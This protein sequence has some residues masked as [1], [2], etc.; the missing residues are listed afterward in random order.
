MAKKYRVVADG[1]FLGHYYGTCPEVAVEKAV[2]ATFDYH[3]EILG[4]PDC[5]FVAKRGILE[6]PVTVVWSDI[7]DVAAEFE[8]PVGE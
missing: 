4:M 3:P 5:E 2:R 6:A 1:Q 8:I 7:P